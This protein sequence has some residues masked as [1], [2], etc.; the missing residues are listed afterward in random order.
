MRAS[1]LISIVLFVSTA[2]AQKQNGGRAAMNMSHTSG[3]GIH[4]MSEGDGNAAAMHS[5]EGHR[6]DMGSHMKMT[7]LREAQPGDQAKADQIVQAARAA[8]DKYKDYKVALADGYKIFLP[9]VEQKQY[10]FTNYW[11]AFRARNNFDPSLPTS[12]LTKRTV[13]GTN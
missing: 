4:E 10:H 11:N 5:M 9:N 1:F 6:M 2:F 12:L 8:A 7:A 13:K 3:E